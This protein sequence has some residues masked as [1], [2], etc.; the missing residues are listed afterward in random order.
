[1]NIGDRHLVQ[2]DPS[3][4]RVTDA[5]CR[6]EGPITRQVEQVFV[7]DWFFCTGEA[8]ALCPPPAGTPGRAVCRSIVDGPNIDPDRLGIILVGAVSSARQRIQIMTPYFLPSREL[9][10]A[11]NAAALRGV[12]VEVILP[13]ESNIP[14]VHWATRKMLWE[15]LQRG[16]HVFYQPPPFAHTKLFVVDSHYAQVGSANLDP[17]SL[18]LNFELNVE[19]YDIPFSRDLSAHMD[20]VRDASRE[21]TLE[22]MDGRPLPIRFRDAI[23]WLFSPFL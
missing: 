8:L 18:R 13:S 10:G 7:E 14:I 21:V 15:L 17:R 12:S 6:L 23:A 3:L 1:M 20:R 2:R 5:H 19:I 11:L 16:V 22:Q 4:V 9:V